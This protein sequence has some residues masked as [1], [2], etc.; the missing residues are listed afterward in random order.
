M[1]VN[2]DFVKYLFTLIAELQTVVKEYHAKMIR[3]E[4]DK[5]DLE[6]QS[7][8][9]DYEVNIMTDKPGNI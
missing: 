5:Y 6:W 1:R 4:G 9:K 8:V 3:L 2:D 7:R